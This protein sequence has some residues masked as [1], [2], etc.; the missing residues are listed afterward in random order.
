MH[1]FSK[2]MSHI[3]TVGFRKANDDTQTLSATLQI[4]VT[5]AMW[6]LAFVHP[7]VVRVQNTVIRSADAVICVL[8]IFC[9]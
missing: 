4:S 9:I 1:G 3:K 7:S 8:I 5:R 2:N 6:L